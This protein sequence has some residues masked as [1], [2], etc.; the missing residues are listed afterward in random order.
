M[1]YQ[2]DAHYILKLISTYFFAISTCSH[3]AV[4]KHGNYNKDISYTTQNLK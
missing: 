3:T 2:Y 1:I 4:K